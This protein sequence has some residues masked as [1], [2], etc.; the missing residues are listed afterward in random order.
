MNK[1][2]NILHAWKG[3]SLQEEKVTLPNGKNITHTTLSHPGAAVILPIDQDGHIIL[4]NQYRPSL[5]KWLI[6]LPAGTIEQGEPAE[7]CALRELAEETGYHAETLTSLGKITPMAGICD[8]IQTL[9]V[10][11]G[12]SRT[13]LQTCDDDEVIEVMSLSINDVEQKIIDGEITDAKTIA[14]LS[15]ARLCQFL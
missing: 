2:L 1:P 11:K 4:I 15:K 12:L 10:A 9:F 8:E 6:E 14:C 13:T 5:K 3:I 7:L